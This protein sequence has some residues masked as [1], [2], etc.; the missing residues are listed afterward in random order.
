MIVRLPTGDADENRGFEMAGV[1]DGVEVLDLSWGISGP[2]T[3]MLLADHGAR[4][5][6]IEPPGGD[7]TR[8]FAGARVWQ[9]GKRSAFLDL[10]D[11]DDLG[12]LAALAETADVLVESFSPGVTHR[13][14]IDFDTLHAINP[15]L[16]YTSITAYGRDNKHSD[17]PGYEALVAARTGQQWES[18]GVEGGTIARLSGIE[19]AL[20]GLPVPDDCWT[21][22]KRPGPLFAGTPWA[23]MATAYLATLATSAALLVREETGRGQHVETSLLQGVLATT[24]GGWQKAEHADAPNFQSWVIDP[25]APKGVFKCK[26]G[27]WIH[28]WTPLPAF[29]IGVSE[30]DHL[31]ITD[32]VTSP[33]DA[34][35]RI[36]L[37]PEEMVLLH[38]YNPIMAERFAKFDSDEWVA[39]A[40]KVGTPV[41]PI[42]SPE[43]ALLDPLL[44]ADGCVVEVDDPELGPVRQVGRVF[45]FHGVPNDPPTAAV[46]P[47]ADTDAVKAEAD[48]IVS[49][50]ALARSAT[51][52]PTSPLE[53]VRVLDLGLAVAGPWGTMMLADLGADVI[54]V[55]TLFDGYWMSNHIG[56]ACN[57]GK[58]S[59]SVNLK[60]PNG[61]D[62]LRRLVE[63]AD[64][65]Q[66]NMRYD[67]AVRLGV[68]YE[69]LKQ[70]K[71]DLVY[72]HTRGFEKSERE[73]L[74][75][76]DQ[77]GAALAGPDWLDGGLDNDGTPLWP[78][79]SLGD[80]GNGFLSAI[81]IVQALYHRDRTGEGQFVD[82]SIIYAQL[83][84]AS[85]GWIT[86]DGSRR[87]DRPQVDQMQMMWN[88][89]YGLY[90]CAD[91]SWLCVTAIE[92]AHWE[93][94]CA[95]IGRDD[96]AG[97][98]RFATAAA[99]TAND[100]ALRAELEGVF[101]VRPA[102]DWFTDLDR[103]G[104]PV[105]V[106]SPD[107]VLDLF[108]DPEFLGRGW[109]AEYDHPAVG[110]M[111]QFGLMFDLSE[112]PG[113]IQGPPLTP[114]MNTREILRELDFDADQIAKL[115]EEKVVLDTSEQV[116]GA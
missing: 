80:T 76:N 64:V 84:N 57:R 46:A 112:T 81:A 22:A 98:A 38:H 79:I 35:M 44:L 12:R 56:M 72:C 86:P 7:P 47:G 34:P 95:A 101:A 30:G 99:R 78:V 2:V 26:D 83:L 54:K 88:A 63:T 110:K 55:N 94:L 87:G 62:V 116:A 73:L 108:A 65:V 49:G 91:D 11:G 20:P 92:D 58:R 111:N 90:P 93:A 48:A 27:R 105:E 102:G 4:V 61:M 40:A 89:L 115:E 16:V 29:V 3:T 97:D 85:I 67:A 33:R 5:T 1:L 39:I 24:V 43:E 37:A 8:G 6:K 103:A 31:E 106:S 36:G 71:P 66:H 9:R 74:P 28:H 77:T 96:L 41:Q 45:Q 114:G 100:A 14:G 59:I 42:R 53:G 15:R 109:I 50:S 107:F 19:G 51:P 70:I 104:V 23:S 69:S 32:E 10:K 18:R 25:R 17:R 68:D 52:A 113:V 60:D 13:L 75:G 82:T 21:A